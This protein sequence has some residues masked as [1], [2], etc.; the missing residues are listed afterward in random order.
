[1]AQS[2]HH[3]DRIFDLAVYSRIAGEGDCPLG[4]DRPCRQ[5]ALL[6]FPVELAIAAQIDLVVLVKIM[7][8][9]VP[10]PIVV[11]LKR[12]AQRVDLAVAFPAPF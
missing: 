9:T 4:V 5:F 3:L 10:A 2:V 1:M 12:L 7:V 6:Q 8:Q 11:D